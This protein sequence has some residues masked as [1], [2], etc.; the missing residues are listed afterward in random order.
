[1]E[2]RG[3]FPVDLFQLRRQRGGS[4]VQR[5]NWGW[6]V[7]SGEWGGVIAS[8]SEAIQLVVQEETGL[9]RRFAPRND[10]EEG[11]SPR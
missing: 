10:G 7:A 1:M 2:K 4:G 3:V 9:P 11:A 5:W 8:G 6:K